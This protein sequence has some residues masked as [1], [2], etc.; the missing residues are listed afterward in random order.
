MSI[1]IINKRLIYITRPGI[2]LYNPAA[3]N[4]T[5][6]FNVNKIAS[7]RLIGEYLD[8]KLIDNER[9]GF[10]KDDNS[11]I[12]FDNLYKIMADEEKIESLK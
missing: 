4:E 6:V 10:S 5:I 7:V 2:S 8:I 11:K 3:Y 12:F 1:Q 9:F